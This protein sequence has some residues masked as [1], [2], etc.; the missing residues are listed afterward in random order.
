ML[1]RV[2]VPE[3]GEDLAGI[4]GAPGCDAS[5]YL[6]LRDVQREGALK[7][8]GLDPGDYSFENDELPW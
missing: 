3:E 1:Y 5:L 2:P 7:G 8:L 6:V 4:D